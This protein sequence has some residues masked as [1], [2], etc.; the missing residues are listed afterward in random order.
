MK[1]CLGQ[2][3]IVRSYD[4]ASAA[5]PTVSTAKGGAF[6]IR[7]LGAIRPARKPD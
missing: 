2:H 4:G 6:C 1:K 7:S 5:A 3:A